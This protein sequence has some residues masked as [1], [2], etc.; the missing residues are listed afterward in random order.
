MGKDELTDISPYEP[1]PIPNTQPDSSMADY[2]HTTQAGFHETP[3]TP[4]DS[5]VLSTLSYLDF[6]AYPYSDV[7]GASFV[8][9]IESCVSRRLKACSQA[10]G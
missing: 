5:L 9:V 8:P 2:L 1:S 10:V 7:H 6:D 3:F 4:V